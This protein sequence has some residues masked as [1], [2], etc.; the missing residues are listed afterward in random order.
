ME[1]DLEMVRCRNPT[2]VFRCA[3]RRRQILPQLRCSRTRRAERSLA[4]DLA[5]SRPALAAEWRGR[6]GGGVGRSH[7]SKVWV[8]GW[9]VDWTG[10]VGSVETRG[11]PPGG[12]FRHTV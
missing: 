5:A 9:V 4:V 2:S 10:E 12:Q 8:T 7:D 1:F 6:V 11:A 3:P